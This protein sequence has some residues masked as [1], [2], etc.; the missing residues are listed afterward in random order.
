MPAAQDRQPVHPHGAFLH[1]QRKRAAYFDSVKVMSCKLSGSA[2]D[3]TAM[4]DWDESMQR[5]QRYQGLVQY[6]SFSH[7]L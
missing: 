6:A 5:L 2:C 4:A 1:L 3:T 7:D